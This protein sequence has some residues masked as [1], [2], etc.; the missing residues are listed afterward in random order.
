MAA[1]FRSGAATQLLKLAVIGVLNTVNFF[2]VLNFLRV[3]GVALYPAVTLAFAAATFVSYVLNRRWTFELDRYAGGLSETSRFYLVN[4]A[5][6]GAT[7][8][9]IWAVDG[10]VGPLDRLGENLAS[11]GAAGVTL[12]PKFVSYRDLVF[13]KAIAAARGARA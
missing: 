2:V 13:G 1:P 10:F 7:V 11:F 3:I 9:F 12:L 5:A 4:V 8:A 6:W